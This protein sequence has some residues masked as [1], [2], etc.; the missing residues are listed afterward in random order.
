MGTQHSSEAAA[1]I[2]LQ[3]TPLNL[4]Q[5]VHKRGKPHANSYMSWEAHVSQFCCPHCLCTKQCCLPRQD[6]PRISARRA[7]VPSSSSSS[8]SVAHACCNT[9][10]GHQQCVTQLLVV[11]V[12]TQ[13]PEHLNLVSEWSERQEGRA[14]VG[15]EQRV[16]PAFDPSH[17]HML[18]L[19]NGRLS[20]VVE[21]VG[22]HAVSTHLHDV[23]GVNVGVAHLDQLLQGRAVLQQHLV[24]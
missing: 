20:R 16:V 2:S 13:A 22:C 21:C 1:G 9:V 11:G 4:E 7:H 17:A 19:R 14:Q 6:C 15:M 18:S 8:P 12:L 3:P 24:P 23:D 10:D 5:Q